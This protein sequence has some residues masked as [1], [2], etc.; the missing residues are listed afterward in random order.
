MDRNTPIC[1]TCQGRPLILILVLLSMLSTACAAPAAS[2]LPPTP[3]PTPPLILT[4]TPASISTGRFT[5]FTLPADSRFPGSYPA[6][7]ASG[8]DGALWFAVQVSNRIGR[9]TPTGSITEFPLPQSGYGPGGRAGRSHLVYR[10][11][12]DRADHSHREH[13]RVCAPHSHEQPWG[14]SSGARP[15]P[16]VYG[17][18]SQPDR[19]DHH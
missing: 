8:P 7:I 13:Y 6:S 17:S 12:P 9:I 4:P 16:L 3:T 18:R 2:T 1:L 11:E 10:R 15:C 5:E 14:Y 19:T